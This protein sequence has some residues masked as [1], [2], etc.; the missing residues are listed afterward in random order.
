MPWATDIA[1][2]LGVPALAFS[3]SSACSFLAKMLPPSLWQCGTDNV[4]PIVHAVAK[5]TAHS[6]KARALVL[7]TAASLERSVLAHIAPRMRDLFTIGPVDAMPSSPAAPCS[8]WREDDGC[9]AWL[10][11]QEDRSV[12][13]VSLVSFTVISHEQFKEFLSGVVAAGYPFLWVL[14]HHAVGCFLTHSGWNST[15]E[16]VVE[17]V[18]MV[19]WPFFADQEINSRFVGAVWRNGLDMKDVCDRAV[20]EKM[21]REAIESNEIRR[22]GEA[23]AQQVKRDVDNGGSSATEFERLVGFIWELGTSGS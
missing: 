23:L 18:P 3:T 8:L 16:A 21:V 15:L 9:L 14:R 2:E 4:N 19:C 11:R 7:N 1:E 20:V 17:G 12:V 22:S 13:Y 10:D 5:A 6:S